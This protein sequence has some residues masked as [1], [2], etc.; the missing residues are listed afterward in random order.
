MGARPRH[1][2]LG[3]FAQRPAGAEHHPARRVGA[4]RA[5]NHLQGLPPPFTT[6]TAEYFCGHDVDRG[7]GGGSDP[8]LEGRHQPIGD[9]P[10]LQH[11]RFK[12]RGSFIGF[13]QS[14]LMSPSL[15]SGVLGGGR[16]RKTG[17]RGAP[18]DRMRA[19]Q[20]RPLHNV[21]EHHLPGQN[22]K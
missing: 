18:E 2:I 11:P 8:V 22:A 17:W 19:P 15:E 6:Y 1:P 16:H 9:V 5:G 7:R 13:L 10:I 3:V 21:G 14:L 20:F 4:V 12:R